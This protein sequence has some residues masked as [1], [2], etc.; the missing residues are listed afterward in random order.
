MGSQAPL[1]LST[2]MATEAAN[3]HMATGRE[4]FE[5]RIRL[6]VDPLSVDPLSS[7]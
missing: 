7:D 1:Q 2:A 4:S 6:N 3:E 5:M